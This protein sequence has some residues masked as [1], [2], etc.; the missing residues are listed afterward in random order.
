[1]RSGNIG[2]LSLRRIIS[3]AVEN[4]ANQVGETLTEELINNNN[5]IN[6]PEAI[7]NYHFPE[8]TEKLNSAKKRFEFEELFYLELLVALRKYNYQSKLTGHKMSINTDLVQNFLKTLPFEL[9]NAQSHRKRS[10]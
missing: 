1:M 2:D 5:L 7:R 6:L 9:T 3:L 8:S 4:Y 10:R